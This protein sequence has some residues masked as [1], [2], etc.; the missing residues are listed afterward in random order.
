MFDKSH[1]E[2]FFRLIF[3]RY[4]DIIYK[5]IYLILKIKKLRNE[6]VACVTVVQG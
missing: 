4:Y 3:F 5:N 6:E 2:K 1:N